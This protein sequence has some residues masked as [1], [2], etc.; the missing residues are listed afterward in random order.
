MFDK[1]GE[2]S[3]KYS[4]PYWRNIRGMDL[5]LQYTALHGPFTY[6]GRDNDAYTPILCSSKSDT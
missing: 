2:D 5:R 3:R 4:T 6:L 1:H